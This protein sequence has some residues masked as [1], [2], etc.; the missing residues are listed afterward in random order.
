MFSAGLFTP[1]ADRSQWHV[2]PPNAGRLRDLPLSRMA[3]S[4]PHPRSAKYKR[5]RKKQ[6]LSVISYSASAALL[7]PFCMPG[8]LLGV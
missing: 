4:L 5:A 7:F 2:S 6:F 3:P 8:A 1:A